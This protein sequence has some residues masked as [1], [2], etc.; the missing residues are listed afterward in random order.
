MSNKNNQGM[1]TFIRVYDLLKIICPANM[2]TETCPLRKE[3]AE[4]PKTEHMECDILPN[5]DL[6]APYYLPKEN[7]TPGKA[8]YIHIN[9]FCAR[10]CQECHNKQK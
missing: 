3:L 7:E 2:T 9:S 8:G 6:I 1:T 4:T 10:I 5:G